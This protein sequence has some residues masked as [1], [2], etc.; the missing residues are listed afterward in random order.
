VR[1]RSASLELDVAAIA[2]L[3]VA[4]AVFV[5]SRRLRRQADDLATADKQLKQLGQHNREQAGRITELEEEVPTEM[6]E[7]MRQEMGEMLI[8][9]DGPA[10]PD[11][12]IIVGLEEPE[13]NP[14]LRRGF[15]SEA[16]AAEGTA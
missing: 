15:A 10:G 8:E 5:A 4:V 12:D 7:A 9:L 2:L 1:R 11:V 3:V 16:I 6:F 13:V 14:A